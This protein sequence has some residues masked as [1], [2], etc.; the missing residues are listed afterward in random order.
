M[1]PFTEGAAG[2]VNPDELN[3]HEKEGLD[4]EGKEHAARLQ[5]RAA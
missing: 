1:V 5:E 3:A 4:K 2:P